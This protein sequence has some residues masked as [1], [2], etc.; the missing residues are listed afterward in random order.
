MVNSNVWFYVIAVLIIIVV[1]FLVIY[2]GICNQW[3]KCLEKSSLMNMCFLSVFGIAALI[4]AGCSGFI[5]DDAAS[6]T[7]I[8]RTFFLATLILLAI[9][10]YVFFVLHAVDSSLMLSILT[11]IVGVGTCFYTSTQSSLAGWLY[12]PLVLFL[13]LVVYLEY[14]VYNANYKDIGTRL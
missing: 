6:Q 13:A 2:Y 9:T 10:T 1:L 11:F 14:Y 4:L 3:Y 12:L 5:A 8:L 7:D